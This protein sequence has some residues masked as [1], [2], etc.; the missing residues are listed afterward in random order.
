L[1]HGRGDIWYGPKTCEMSDR[2]GDQLEAEGL[3]IRF[4]RLA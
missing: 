3:D 4:V 2:N 1:G